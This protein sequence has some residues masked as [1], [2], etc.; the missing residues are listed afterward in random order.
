M[1]KTFCN[2]CGIELDAQKLS[3]GIMRNVESFPIF[4]MAGPTPGQ[5]IQ[6][7]IFQ[8]V[9]DL[10]EDCQKFVWKIVEERKVELARTKLIIGK[11]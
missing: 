10:C 11:S 3:G 4:P 5:M 8:E 9:W 2:L 1:Q 7:R 6:K